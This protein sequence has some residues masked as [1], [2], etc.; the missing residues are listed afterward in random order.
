MPPWTRRLPE[1]KVTLTRRETGPDGTFGDV[2]LNDG[3]LVTVLQTMERPWAGNEKDVS[4][5]LPEPGG[6]AIIYP[7]LHLFSPAHGNCYHLQRVQGRTEVEMHSANVF[8]QLKGCIALGRA[9]ATFPK[10]A[11]LGRGDHAITLDRAQKGITESVAA[12]AI[13][14][15]LTAKQPLELEVRWA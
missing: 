10:G 9:V 3:M 8:Q 15:R 5:I 6:A 1:M 2:S 11:V 12:M 13:F 7:A 4:C 14:E